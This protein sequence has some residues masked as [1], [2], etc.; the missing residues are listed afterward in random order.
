MFISENFVFLELHKTGCSHIRHVLN[1]LFDGELIGQHN[2]VGPDLFTE[3]RVFLGS[4]RDPWEWYTSLWSYGCDSKGGVFENVTRK[5]SF[6][7]GLGWRNNP[8]T[9]FLKLIHSR[10]PK[11][12]RDT[13][14]D[15]NDAEAFR[16]WLHMM[17]DSKY[18]A[19]IGE[20]Y[21]ECSVS[22]IAG[23]LTFR[24]LTLF[25]TRLGE[26]RNL[27]QLSTFEQIKSYDNENCFIDH[28]IRNENLEADLFR[29]IEE[30]GVQIPNN[31]KS[32]ILSRPKTNTSSRKHGPGYYYDIESENLVAE[33][34][35]LII[36]K[37]GYVA[38][39]LRTIA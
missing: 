22:R 14:K 12:W 24:Y 4:V 1:D 18:S 25:C 35:R 30:F 6:I 15:V 20:G 7:R 32:K 26:K 38:P 5:R 2:Q 31:I 37:F 13:Y 23:I 16:T 3:E 9:A 27:N 11:K 36:E 21:S 29:G 33:K 39:S 19:D 10:D 8:Y 28:F 34:E 17:H